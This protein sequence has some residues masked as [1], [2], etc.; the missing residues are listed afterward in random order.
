MKINDLE[1]FSYCLGCGLF[2]DADKD[3]DTCDD[4][5]AKRIRVWRVKE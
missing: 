1:E 5:Q 4:C 2:F 3:K